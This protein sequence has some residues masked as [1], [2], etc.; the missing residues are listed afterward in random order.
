MPAKSLAQQHLMG[1]ALAVKRGKKNISSLPAGLQSKVRPLLKMTDKQLS[2][3]A[4]H[5]LKELVS[6]LVNEILAEDDGSDVGVEKKEIEVPDFEK[7]L[8]LPQN[9]GISFT[10]Q[11]KDSTNIP[12]LK[13][14]F[15]KNVFEIRYK[16]T[17]DV[18]ED[19]KFVKTN[20]TTVVKK[21]RVGNNVVY[22]TFTLIESSQPDKTQDDVKT[23][24]KGAPE[25]P[26]LKKVIEMTSNSVPNVNGDPELFMEFLKNVN[27]DIGL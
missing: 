24:E 25:K 20:K 9:I 26:E 3:Y 27:E 12:N 18:V 22:K 21:I 23:P 19:G 4:K 6:E 7:Y 11:E 8:K 15:A 10:Q 16:S 13:P 2:D 5:R 14:P 1:L 17:E